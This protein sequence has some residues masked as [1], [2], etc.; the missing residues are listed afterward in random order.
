[1]V[2]CCDKKVPI[3][4]LFKFSLTILRGVLLVAFLCT[5]P[6][7]QPLPVIS[8]ITVF[9]YS[10]KFS[11]AFAVCSILL[12]LLILNMTCWCLCLCC[13]RKKSNDSSSDEENSNTTCFKNNAGYIYTAAFYLFKKLL[14]DLTDYPCFKKL[15]YGTLIFDCARYGLFALSVPIF[16][17][18]DFGVL[19]KKSGYLTGLHAAALTFYMIYFVAFSLHFVIELVRLIQARKVQLEILDVF[20]SDELFSPKCKAIFTKSQYG[21]FACSSLNNKCDSLEP[22]HILKCHMNYMKRP[23]LKEARYNE[24]GVNMAVG[25]HRTSI[26]AMVAI[27]DSKM[28]PS[29]RDNLWLGHGIYFANNLAATSFKAVGTSDK[30][31]GAIICAKVDLGRYKTIKHDFLI[32]NGRQDIRLDQLRS[33]RYNSVYLFHGEENKDEFTIPDADQII[34]YVVMVEENAIAEYRARMA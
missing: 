8:L 29:E 31:L 22:E 25:F 24:N 9:I 30:P 6:Y 15:R 18:V 3:L 10:L 7:S 4:K 32:A 12:V 5:G 14:W 2:E 11:I 17:G 13:C 19:V 28:K 20:G 27:K 33:E 23:E 1:M 21:L 16:V 34:E 26:D